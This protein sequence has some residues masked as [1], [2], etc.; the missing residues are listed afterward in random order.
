MRTP[1]IIGNWK[2]NKTVPE[3]IR[4]ITELKG[5]FSGK[6]EIE[7]AV[8]PSFT[9]LHP[10]EIAAQGTPIKIAAQDLFY[11]ESGAYTGEVSPAML[12]DVGCTY[13]IV[14]HSERRQHFGETDAIVNKKVKAALESELR[15]V[16]CVGE[17]KA[18]RGA[19]KTF[20]IVEG[21]L[22]A[23][24]RGVRDTEAENVV[25]AYEPIWA[26]G[27]GETATPGTAQEV[28]QFL[29]EKIGTIFR[30]DL[31]QKMRIIYG[32]SVTRDNIKDLMAQ[33][34]IDGALVG[35]ASLD[36]RS[37]VDIVHYKE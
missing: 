1:L 24:L 36:A 21:Q 37:F 19:G 23:C 28:H 20:E 15:P 7:I 35:G 30:R 32:G 34:D 22:R 16:M 33:A 14:G 26:I 27:T 11:E 25:V 29:R 2:M 31:S 10:A 9:A 8:A 18:E 13:V 5:L 17:S 3:T 6:Q 4:A 12:L